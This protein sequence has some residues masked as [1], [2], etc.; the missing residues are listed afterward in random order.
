MKSC[1][2]FS[3]LLL[4]LS[5]QVEAKSIQYTVLKNE[6]RFSTYF[7]LIGKKSYEG[8]VIKESLRVRTTYDL[9]DAKG[10]YEG[11]GICRALSLGSLYNWAREIDVYGKDGNKIGFI[12]GKV[13]TTAQAKFHFFDQTSRLVAIAFLD[14]ESAGCTI[15][16][17]EVNEKVLGLLTRKISVKSEDEWEAIIYDSH[18]VDPKLIKIFSAFIADTQNF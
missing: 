6:Y 9:Y 11:Q 3:F 13:F 2:L 14:F 12:E 5:F 10:D 18:A 4:V 15:C 7:E 17:P 8:R 1:F 16:D